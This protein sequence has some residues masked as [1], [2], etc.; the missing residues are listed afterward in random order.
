MSCLSTHGVQ[1]FAFPGLL[2]CY[3]IDTNLPHSVKWGFL[4]SGF[5]WGIWQNDNHSRAKSYAKGNSGSSYLYRLSN[6]AGGSMGL[7]GWTEQRTARQQM[8]SDA[9]GVKEMTRCYR[10]GQINGFNAAWSPG[11]EPCQADRPTASFC[12]LF[13]SQKALHLHDLQRTQR[14]QRALFLGILTPKNPDHLYC[15]QSQTSTDY[16]SLRWNINVGS[17]LS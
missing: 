5:K 9:P 12:I 16:H 3:S 7:L 17:F 4:K 8:L 11:R 14:E 15:C 10:R 6:R 1:C 2:A 13:T